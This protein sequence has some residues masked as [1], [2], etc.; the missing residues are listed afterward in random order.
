MAKLQELF[1]EKRNVVASMR[2][3]AK[4]VQDNKYTPEQD[5]QFQRANARLT[6][7]DQQIEVLKRAQQLEDL[8]NVNEGERQTPNDIKPVQATSL[9]RQSV[10]AKIKEQGEKAL[11]DHER[12]IKATIDKETTVFRKWMTV[13]MENLNSEEKALMRSRQERAQSIG[14]PSAGGYTVPEGFSG[15]IVERLKF[16]SQLL[17]WANIM[18]TETGNP[19]PF[20]YNDDT[21]NT[22]ELIG[23]NA[24]LSSSSADLV[25]SVFTLS[26]YKL[27]SKMIKVSNE[28]LQD[29]GVNLEAYLGKQLAT[30]VG[31]I[32]NTYA[33]TGS[34]T[35]QPQGYITGASQGKVAASQT[36]FTADELIDL[37]HSVDAAYRMSPKCAWAFHDLVLANIKKLSNSSSDDR[38]LWLPSIRESEPDTLYGKPYFVNNDMASTLASGN[39]VVAFGDWDYF[40][41]RMVNAFSLKRLNERYAEYDQA[42]FFGLARM[43]TRVMDTNAIKY[44]ELT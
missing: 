29:N 30:R 12:G 38:P 9:E 22:G 18:T 14:T 19:I 37:M 3:M 5:A 43:D 35:S 20:P 32:F 33:T 7:I 4:A 24:D 44:L 25:F 11:S 28:L 16:I 36:A 23:E 17:N 26:A 2:D 42:A 27:S 13:G 21:S 34:G 41:V 31:R 40:A 8:E 1:D 15:Y 10:L 39:K 6:E